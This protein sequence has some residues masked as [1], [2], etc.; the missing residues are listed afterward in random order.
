MRANPPTGA[1]TSGS[2]RGDVLV[3]G[4]EQGELLVIPPTGR[5]VRLGGMS[6]YRLAGARSP[7][8]GSSGTTWR[9]C[10]SWACPQRPG[11]GQ[12][13]TSQARLFGTGLSY[14]QAG[15]AL[16]DVAGPCLL[17]RKPLWLRGLLIPSPRG[18]P[19]VHILGELAVPGVIA[20]QPSLAEPANTGT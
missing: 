19:R 17:P 20:P 11:S 9:C 18:D 4:T 3:Q 16:P 2:E 6:I 1:S 10:S 5:H 8:S 12:R 13:R 14:A 15:L 7:S